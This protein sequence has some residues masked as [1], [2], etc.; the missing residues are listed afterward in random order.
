MNHLPSWECIQNH[1]NPLQ[2]APQ[3]T[4]DPH[5]CRNPLSRTSLERERGITIKSHPIR[6]SFKHKD[7]K[8]YT[9]NL[10]DTPNESI[11]Y[12]H[13]FLHIEKELTKYLMNKNPELIIPINKKTPQVTHHVLVLKLRIEKLKITVMSLRLSVRQ[14]QICLV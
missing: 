6:M 1:L 2:S 8:T 9:F 10:I 3:P 4:P 13:Y 5:L 7:N 11:S 12:K 14:D